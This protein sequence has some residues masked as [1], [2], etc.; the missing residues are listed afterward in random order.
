MPTPPKAQLKVNALA[1]LNIEYKEYLDE[2]HQLTEAVAKLEASTPRDQ[3]E[4]KRTSQVL[5]ET[6]R[7][8]ARVLQMLKEHA[9]EVKK[10]GGPETKSPKAVEALELAAKYTK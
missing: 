8:R 7:V 6:K 5:E 3:Y 2:E 9:A 1:R 10:L 4:I